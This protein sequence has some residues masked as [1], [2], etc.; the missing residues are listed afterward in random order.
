M[1][2]SKKIGGAEM[3]SSSRRVMTILHQS[4]LQ[5][6]SIF[7]KGIQWRALLCLKPILAGFLLGFQKELKGVPLHLLMPFKNPGFHK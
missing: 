6:L 5:T 7:L 4:K 1:K 3:L 2:H